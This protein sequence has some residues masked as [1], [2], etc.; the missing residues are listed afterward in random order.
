MEDIKEYHQR[1]KHRLNQYAAGPGYLDWDTQPNPFRRYEGAERTELP[2]TQDLPDTPYDALFGGGKVAP[3]LLNLENVSMFLRL[4]LSLAAWKEYQGARWAVRVNPSS[5]NL[6]AEE[7]YIVTEGVPGLGEGVYHYDSSGH[8][9]ERRLGRS[10][11][12]MGLML[13]EYERRD[14]PFRNH[15]IFLVG[16]TSIH[17]REAWK[18]GE[19]A[20]RYCQLDVG[21]ALLCLR[22]AAAS[23]GWSARLAT[24]ASDG[25]AASL[26]GVSR[27]E[28]YAGAETEYPDTMVIVSAGA[29]MPED[30]DGTFDEAARHFLLNA[31]RDDSWQGRAN[32]ISA[33]HTHD[34]PIIDEAARLVF[35]PATEEEFTPPPEAPKLPPSGCEKSAA[36]I[37][38]T[39]RSGQAYDGASSMPAEKFLRIISALIPRPGM[40]PWDMI[41]W[42][43]NV[44]PVF[45]VN[46][47]EGFAP[48]I[49]IL[50]RRPGEE[51]ALGAAMGG[52]YSWTRPN[53][54]PEGLPLYL[55]K[56][57]DARG[58]AAMISCQQNI[59]GDGAFSVAMVARFAGP[60]AIGPWWYRRIHWEAGAV[61][62]ALYLEAEATG[63]RGTGI[64]CYFDDMF[65][66]TLGLEGDLFQD[67]YHFTVGAAVEDERVVSTP[68]YEER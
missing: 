25:M 24:G 19:R 31:A 15:G 35:K 8:A 16:L 7:G 30:I 59:A 44:H 5:G 64:G 33:G 9:L 21:H 68:P 52:K 26:L 11:E 14:N 40:P 3:R 62:Q 28:D 47:V 2:L 32:V 1:T 17:W 55:L 63:F 34:W 50:V 65:H 42:Q 4:S 10:A 27:E 41:P 12:A 20:F 36:H 66:S 67:I 38:M 6:H 37:I 29:G 18:Y 49:Y 61:G 60:L 56:E 46:R 48:G 51:E 57:M 53:A 43:A 54:S 22:F 45:F 39:R 58:T 13:D 23:L